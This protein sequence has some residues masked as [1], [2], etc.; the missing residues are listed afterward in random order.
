MLPRPLELV[1]RLDSSRVTV[2]G[3]L[4][5]VYRYVRP[6]RGRIALV[7]LASLLDMAL[8]AAIS[9]SFKFL[10]DRAIGQKDQRA[11]Y[12]V[13]GGLTALIVCVAVGGF[14]RDRVYAKL[15]SQV[16]HD[17]GIYANSPRNP[18]VKTV[19]FANASSIAAWICFARRKSDLDRA[20]PL[21]S[22]ASSQDSAS[23][24]LYPTR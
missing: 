12:Y 19:P 21:S 1:D 20:C 8:S 24:S 11:L 22:P 9:L 23:N 7:V 5:L 10:I 16:L 13:A 14:W 17:P 15:T 3:T 18:G 2:G 4:R 6:Q